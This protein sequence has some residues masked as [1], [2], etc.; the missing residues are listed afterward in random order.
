M[1]VLGETP[2]IGIAARVLFLLL[3]VS[4]IPG[5][6]QIDQI[7]KP[8]VERH[9]S[10]A[11]ADI[12]KDNALREKTTSE[13]RGEIASLKEENKEL[14]EK[15]ASL[16]IS[17]YVNENLLSTIDQ[18]PASVSDGDGYG[19]GR[20]PHG[21]VAI[22]I[23]KVQ[24]YLDGYKVTLRIGNMAAASMNG[25][26]FEVEW[27]LRYGTKNVTASQVYASKK[28]KTFSSTSQFPS[29]AYTLVDVILTPATPDEVKTLS[30]STKWNI[31]SLRMPPTRA[32][33]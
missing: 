14:R 22:V 28:K 6:D 30:V 7:V 3:L 25:G 5:C 1:P 33:Q 31:I 17:N 2:Q 10:K 18:R 12:Q 23:D 21:P 11:A 29:G 26:E 19:I 15:I 16:E 4:V 27:G 20:T 8:S 24:P 9:L 13:I 32:V